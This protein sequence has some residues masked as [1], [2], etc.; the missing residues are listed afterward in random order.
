MISF[1]VNTIH[2]PDAFRTGIDDATPSSPAHL[3]ELYSSECVEKEK[4]KRNSPKFAVA[5][6]PASSAPGARERH[7]GSSL[8]PEYPDLVAFVA[9]LCIKALRLAT[10]QL[11]ENRAPFGPC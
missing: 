11:P 3:R 8:V 7:F 6:D 9:V 4:K 2:V 1:S 5:S 10:A